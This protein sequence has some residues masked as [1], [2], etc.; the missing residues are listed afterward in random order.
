MMNRERTPQQ[1]KNFAFY[2]QD[3]QNLATIKKKNRLLRDSDALRFA[4]ALAASGAKP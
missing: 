2:D 1:I 3:L 4:L